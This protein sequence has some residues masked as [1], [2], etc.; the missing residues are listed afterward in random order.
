M[1][2]LAPFF[3]LPRWGST[4]I[5]TPPPQLSSLCESPPGPQ[6]HQTLPINH[7][8]RDWG[9]QGAGFSSLAEYPLY[10]SLLET[11]L[12]L[13]NS[14]CKYRFL[15]Y[16]HAES[17]KP[18]RP[19]SSPWELGGRGLIIPVM[20]PKGVPWVKPPSASQ[21]LL[22][23][24]IYSCSATINGRNEPGKG[25]SECGFLEALAES[26]RLWRNMKLA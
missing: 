23:A 4:R 2:K 3:P 18:Q 19:H 21:V 6:V 7:P 5:S 12:L 17:W 1:G 22:P 10:V 24:S 15:W 16:W 20:V 13:G 14:L 11:S 26:S 8:C 9:Y 25:R